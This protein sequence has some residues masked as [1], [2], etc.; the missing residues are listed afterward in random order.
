VFNLI[1]LWFSN[2]L[3]P[4]P[5]INVLY[6]A[7]LEII[8][9][10]RYDEEKKMS[11]NKIFVDECVKKREELLKHPKFKKFNRGE[12]FR[13][14]VFGSIILLILS[15]I[16]LFLASSDTKN[17]FLSFITFVLVIAFLIPLSIFGKSFLLLIGLKKAGTRDY[18][19]WNGMSDDR[20]YYE[21]EI[22]N[23]NMFNIDYL[24]E[25]EY[26]EFRIVYDDEN[27]SYIYNKNGVILT[28]SQIKEVQVDDRSY[29]N[30]KERGI[31]R[32]IE[33]KRVAQ[34]YTKVIFEDGKFITLLNVGEDLQRKLEQLIQ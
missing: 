26:K 17:D 4:K 6:L 9:I 23:T 20:A 30:V 7:L 22:Y 5:D 33:T 28:S 2:L 29:S 8:K 18:L 12:A 19:D 31:S 14:F 15:V 25:L 16:F 10:Q 34:V 32:T 11:F 3:N 24:D 21:V 27:N 13:S 1:K